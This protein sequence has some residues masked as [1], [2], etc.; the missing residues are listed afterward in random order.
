G[1]AGGV[2]S[3]VLVVD[4]DPER[5][6][7][8]HGHL[9]T[10]GWTVAAVTSGE[11]ALQALAHEDFDVVLT[12]LVMDRV[13]GMAL[14]QEAQQHVPNPRVILMTAFGSIESAIEALRQAAY[15]YLTKPFTLQEATAAISPRHDGPRRST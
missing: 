15:D 2:T 14:L 1:G 10:E 3:R 6:D 11:A 9:A 12:D 7:R 4:S 5:V 8:L 13:D